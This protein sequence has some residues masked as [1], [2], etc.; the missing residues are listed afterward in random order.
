MINY[1]D[2]DISEGR[3]ATGIDMEGNEVTGEITNVMHGFRMISVTYGKDRLQ[4][5]IMEYENI[6]SIEDERND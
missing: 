3:I 1:N 5:C 4:K 6:K 2:N